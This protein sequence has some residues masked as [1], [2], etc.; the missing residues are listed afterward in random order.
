M[1]GG[2]SRSSAGSPVSRRALIIGQNNVSSWRR[3]TNGF[4]TSA[5]TFST[6]REYV[7]KYDFIA[8]EDLEVKRMMGSA[9]NCRNITD[10]AWSTFLHML[11]YKAERA[12]R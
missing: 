12:G 5:L 11:T 4:A 9:H 3:L 7:D 6:S 8:V 1:R 2:L 10:S